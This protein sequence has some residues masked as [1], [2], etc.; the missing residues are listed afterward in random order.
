MIIYLAPDNIE[1][2][3][4]TQIRTRIHEDIVKLYTEEMKAGSP[5]PALEVFAEP[6]SKRY[7][8]ADGFHRHRAYVNVGADKI[9]CK[10]NEGG[11]LEALI[12]ALGANDTHGF[13]RTNAD[14]Q[15]AVRMALK[16]PTIGQMS[17][18]EIGAI[19]KVSH[20]TVANIRN[21][22]QLD[23]SRR[24]D[25]DP[26]DHNPNGKKPTDADEGDQR[27]RRPATQAEVETREVAE[28]LAAIKALPYHGDWAANKLNVTPD[29]VKDMQF[30]RD[31]LT[32]AIT[33]CTAK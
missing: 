23:D 13:R 16:D 25:P 17:L 8:L 12:H 22:M 21:R 30:V 18:R 4:A 26:S 10:L 7:I 3:A 15:L 6:G 27:I 14:K 2:T 29:M 31:W 5:F 28:A 20:G 11:M 9:P 24:K 19:C 33:V 1:A 32:D